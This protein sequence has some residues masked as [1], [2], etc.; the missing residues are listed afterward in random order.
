M[1]VVLDTQWDFLITLYSL[2]C[3]GYIGLIAHGKF[4]KFLAAALQDY[5]PNSFLEACNIL[6]HNYCCA[7]VIP[8]LTEQ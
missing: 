6:L 4:G 1:L 8:H 2:D 7:V 3:F 5:G